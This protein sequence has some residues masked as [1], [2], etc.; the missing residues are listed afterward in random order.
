MVDKSHQGTGETLAT[1]EFGES[2]QVEIVD[3]GD[4]DAWVDVEGSDVLQQGTRSTAREAVKQ[5][6]RD[7][8]D[9][10]F[11]AAFQG[12]GPSDCTEVAAQYIERLVVEGF[13]PQ[14]NVDQLQQ[15]VGDDVAAA[16]RERL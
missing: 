3:D 1:L 4:P 13:I 7:V 2:G 16:V 11:V 14:D 9:E 5:I 10:D 8:G 12:G 6:R 15:A